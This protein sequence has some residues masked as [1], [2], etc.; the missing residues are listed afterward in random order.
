[1]RELSEL[2]F[3]WCVELTEALLCQMGVHVMQGEGEVWVFLFP[4]FY[5]WEFP[6]RSC[7]K[8]SAGELAGWAHGRAGLLARGPG[9][10]AGLTRDVAVRRSNAVLFPHHCGQTCFDNWGIVVSAV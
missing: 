6:L 8:V 3:G 7:S 5:Y 2:R 4:N 10:R 1:V 9:S